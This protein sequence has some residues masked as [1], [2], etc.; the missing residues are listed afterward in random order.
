[1]SLKIS[2]EWA[3]PAAIGI[4]TLMAVTGLLMFF[5]LDSGLQK[6]VHEWAGWLVVAAVV[7]HAAAN[8][9]GFKRYF[10]GSGKSPVILGVCAL[11]LAGTFFSL[12]GAAEQASPPAL[13][14]RA[15]SQAP[16]GTV[17]ALFGKTGEQ[18]VKDLAAAGIVLPNEQATIGSAI[19][20]DREKMGQALRAI[21]R[22]AD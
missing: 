18:A 21:S 11:V 19:E 1:M 16:V 20:G 15:M 8:W 13:A 2:R 3:T 4:F 10:T 22:K 17:A 6:T 12:P 9:L 5:H 14:M 7:A